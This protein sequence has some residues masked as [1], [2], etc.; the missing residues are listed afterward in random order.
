MD[1]LMIIYFLLSGADIFSYKI[2]GNTIR[3]VN[4]LSVVFCLILVVLK[5]YKINRKILIIYLPVIIVHVFSVFYSF[6]PM[7]SLIYLIYI[8]FYLLFT[9]NLIYSWGKNREVDD[10]I[11]I[12]I[13]S[14]RI[15]SILTIIQFILGNIRILKLLSYQIY[16]GIF[17]PALWFYE[18][19]YLATFLS[20]YYML[21]LVLRKR[22]FKDFLLSL[23][24]ISLTTSST[25]YISIVTGIIIYLILSNE[26]FEKRVKILLFAFLVGIV[27]LSGIWLIKSSIIDIFIKRLFIDGISSSSGVRMKINMETLKV[28]RENLWVGIGANTFQEYFGCSPMNVILEIFTT[29]GLIGGVIFLLFFIVVFIKIFKNK[30]LRYQ[31]LAISFLLFFIVLQANQNYM[32]LYMWNHLGLMLLFL[33]KAKERK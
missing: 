31:G 28:I 13:I 21:T 5:K 15:I 29:L 20:L 27:V 25:G 11:N 1:K 6:L 7:N 10:I 30:D 33:Q 19:S 18:P 8:I 17:R 3:I 24:A 23:L 16:R 26:K 9:L 32:R 14:F 2:F 22:Y 4:I 12:Y